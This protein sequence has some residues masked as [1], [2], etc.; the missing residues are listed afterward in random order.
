[1]PTFQ[2]RRRV[3]FTPR[4]MFDLVADVEK[5]PQFLPLCDSLVVRSREDKGEAIV[6]VASMGVGYMAIR[7]SFTSRV[8]LYPQAPEV[9]VEYLD[10]PFRRLENRWG[11][12]AVPG[13]CD[14]EFFIDYEF[15]SVMLGM[16]MGAM[17]DRAFRRFAEAFEQRA[18]A[19]YGRPERAPASGTL[20]RL[21]D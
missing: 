6:L 8:T 21:I 15:R 18:G 10:G 12:A 14:V 3:P 19:V 20:D 2:T 13:G 7:E 16:L 5:Y 17:F 11:F 9:L 1:M 4:Q